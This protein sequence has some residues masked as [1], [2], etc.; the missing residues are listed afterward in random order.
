M[1]R[2][3]GVQWYYQIQFLLFVFLMAYS[4]YFAS[5]F[6]DDKCYG[7]KQVESCPTRRLLES[8]NGNNTDIDFSKE[9]SI[10]LADVSSTDYNYADTVNLTYFDENHRFLATTNVTDTSTSYTAIAIVLAFIYISEIGLLFILI[11]FLYYFSNLDIAKFA[12][13][14]WCQ[15]CGG[16]L[17]KCFPY[18]I[19][20]A[21]YAALILVL[22]EIL[23]VFGLKNCEQAMHNDT[24]SG[25]CKI[26]QLQTE[27]EAYAIVVVILW[28]CMHIIGGFIRRNVYYDSFFYQPEDKSKVWKNWCFVKCGP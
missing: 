3:T 8:G 2:C 28:A 19:V 6:A 21:H 15:R 11:L 24:A 27:G 26:G 18:L 5:K 13:L 17:S 9:K 25:D 4:F 1:G 20:L 23:L 22:V 16:K 14:G 10:F 7:K 12:K